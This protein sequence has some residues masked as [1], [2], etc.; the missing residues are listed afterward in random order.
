M[1]HY[2]MY[3]YMHTERHTHLLTIQK[4][5]KNALKKNPSSKDREI[6]QVSSNFFE[7]RVKIN[8][9]NILSSKITYYLFCYHCWWWWW[10]WVRTAG[11][12]KPHYKCNIIYLPYKVHHIVI[13]RSNYWLSN[14]YN[15]GFW[16]VSSLKCKVQKVKDTTYSMRQ[17]YAIK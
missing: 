12:M 17:I 7:R 11:W 6:W 5:N 3:K 2:K 16:K 1:Y 14:Q 8:W 4:Q 10:W 9:Q 15:F 13:T